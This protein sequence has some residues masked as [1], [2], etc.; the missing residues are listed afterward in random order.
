MASRV[1]NFRAKNYK[2]L[3]IGFHVTVENVRDAFFGTQCR[4]AQCTA[5]WLKIKLMIFDETNITN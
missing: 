3:I 5:N 2:N 4:H 1:Q